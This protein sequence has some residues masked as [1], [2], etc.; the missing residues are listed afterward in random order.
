M[1]IHVCA[2]VIVLSFRLRTLDYL[3][4]QR[5]RNMK[6]KL[7][8]ILVQPQCTLIGEYCLSCKIEDGLLYR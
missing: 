7:Y 6:G 5:Q 3:S 1:M 2:F 4:F 8:I